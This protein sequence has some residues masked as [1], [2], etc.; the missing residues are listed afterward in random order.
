[1]RPDIMIVE[2]DTS[3]GPGGE[4]D[5]LQGSSTTQHRPLCATIKEKRSLGRFKTETIERRRN[6]WILERG[7]CTDTKVQDEIDEK[8]KQHKTLRELL[9]EYGYHVTHTAFPLGNAG[10]LYTAKFTVLAEQLGVPRKEACTMLKKLHMHAITSLHR[11]I[12]C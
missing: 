10:T 1:M 8:M 6:I 7:Y 12:K 4:L 3:N 2:L 5:Y 11:I 9:F